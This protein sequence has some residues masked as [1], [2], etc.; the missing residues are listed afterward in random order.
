MPLLKIGQP[1]RGCPISLPSAAA[2]GRAAV[3]HEAEEIPFTAEAGLCALCELPKHLR[4]IVPAEDTATSLLQYIGGQESRAASPLSFVNDCEFEQHKHNA[5][6][7]S[8]GRC[9]TLG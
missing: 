1:A 5:H 6:N 9:C 8:Y 2:G 4:I 7:K 3:F